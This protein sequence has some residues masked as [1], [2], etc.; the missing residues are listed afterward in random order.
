MKWEAQAV[1][2]PIDD[3]HKPMIPRRNT[4]VYSSLL[5]DEGQCEPA[6]TWVMHQGR[7]YP[8]DIDRNSIDDKRALKAD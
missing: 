1:R 3:N 2:F 6:T 8:N 5:D 4:T 7:A